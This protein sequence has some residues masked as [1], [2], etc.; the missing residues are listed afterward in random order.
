MHLP[1]GW[2]AIP[3]ERGML[4]GNPRAAAAVAGMRAMLGSSSPARPASP[5]LIHFKLCLANPRDD[6][7]RYIPADQLDDCRDGS[8]VFGCCQHQRPAEPS[9]TAGPADAMDIILGM[10]RHIEAED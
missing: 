1:R 3:A 4:G 7:H 8:A 2:P 9:G 6:H 5:A 10:D